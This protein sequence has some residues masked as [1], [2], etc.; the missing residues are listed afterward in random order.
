MED[1][2]WKQ[3]YENLEK[4]F[5]RLSQSIDNFERSWYMELRKNEEN[6]LLTD[7]QFADLQDLDLKREGIVQRFEYTYELFIN[8]LRDLFIHIGITKD[9]IRGPRDVLSQAL[10]DHWI[11]DHDGW[12]SMMKSRNLT[13]HTYDQSI[14]DAISEDISSKYLPLMKELF[15]KLANEY[16]RKS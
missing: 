1:I 7:R 3:R 14:A 6:N 8:T 12:R 15:I 16:N 2:R 10:K 5:Q 9:D 13:S 4:A 11:D